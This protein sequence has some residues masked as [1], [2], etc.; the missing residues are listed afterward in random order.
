MVTASGHGGGKAPGTPSAGEPAQIPANDPAV[1]RPIIT[2]GPHPLTSIIRGCTVWVERTSNPE[3]GPRRAEILSIRERPVKAT[4]DGAGVA[5]F[6]YYVHY[7]AFNKRLDDWVPADRLLLDREVEWPLPPLAG[8][9]GHNKAPLSKATSGTATPMVAMSPAPASTPQQKK[10]T[11]TTQAR[12]PAARGKARSKRPAAAGT[13]GKALEPARGGAQQQQGTPAH[14]SNGDAM[15]VDGDDVD[16]ISG[17]IEIEQVDGEADAEGE[18]D[19]GT[20]ATPAT[21]S[22]EVEIEK[23]RTHGSMTQS[24]H[25][26]ARVKNLDKIQ[27]G[28]SLVEAWYFSPYPVE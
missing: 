25:E 16:T 17:V 24:V 3:P 12:R 9:A 10:K 14:S 4:G 2:P 5:T 15:D 27:M 1:R 23:L 11:T 13:R 26:I 20:P 21:F 7:V 18:E 8:G 22:K 19:T 28:Q 6:E